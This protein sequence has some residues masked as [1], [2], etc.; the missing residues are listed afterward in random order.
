[1][2]GKDRNFTP[3]TIAPQKTRCSVRC[4]RSGCGSTTAWLI[5]SAKQNPGWSDEQIFQQAKRQVTGLIQHITY[6]EF[7]PALL[8]AT[9]SSPTTATTRRLIQESALS[10]P[11]RAY[12]VGHTLISD[13]LVKVDGDGQELDAIALKDSFFN[14]QHILKGGIDAYPQWRQPSRAQEVDTQLVDGLRNFLFPWQSGLQRRGPKLD[15]QRK[16]LLKPVLKAVTTALPT[17]TASGKPLV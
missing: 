6:N 17:T 10:S 1:M 9:S 2:D 15:L 12:R 8:G 13:Q 11:Q 7:L 3:E 4:T 14:V 5:R 16:T